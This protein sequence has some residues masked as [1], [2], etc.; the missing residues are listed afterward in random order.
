MDWAWTYGASRDIWI[1]LVIGFGSISV[2]VAALVVSQQARRLTE[3]AN[4]AE[5]QRHDAEAS[6]RYAERLDDAV[7]DFVRTFPGRI[8]QL[9]KRRAELREMQSKGQVPA[10]PTADA[11]TSGH[12]AVAVIRLFARG[13]DQKAA[14]TLAK[15]LLDFDDLL[16]DKAAG[17]LGDLNILLRQWRNG[18]I[19]GD[20]LDTE[21]RALRARAESDI[22]ER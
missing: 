13:G 6:A 20:K 22:H 16:A 4:R 5:A 11:F 8:A 12:P 21:L 7:A 2:A 19:D 9:T 15:V 3:Q 10:D 1:P 14:A 18:D 17:Y